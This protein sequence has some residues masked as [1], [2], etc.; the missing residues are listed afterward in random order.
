MYDP[1]AKSVTLFPAERLDL[2]NRYQ[3]TVNGM[4][5]AA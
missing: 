3:L 2:H 1:S 5:P 4:A